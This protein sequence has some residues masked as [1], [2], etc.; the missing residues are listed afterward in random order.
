MNYTAVTLKPIDY[1]PLIS[2]YKGA[3]VSP[4]PRFTKPTADSMSGYSAVKIGNN[5][6]AAAGVFVTEILC[7]EKTLRAAYIGSYAC[8]AEIDEVDH[9]L[10]A[11]IKDMLE[12]TA[13]DILVCED[14]PL[15]ELLGFENKAYRNILAVSKEKLCPTEES[16]EIQNVFA[17]VELKVIMG[18]DYTDLCATYENGVH[19]D[20]PHDLL[21]LSLCSQSLKP[22]IVKNSRGKVIALM[23][24][25][26]DGTIHELH[27]ACPHDL[28]DI[29]K[30]YMILHGIKTLSVTTT[31]CDT[32]V[33][34]EILPYSIGNSLI[35]TLYYKGKEADSLYLSTLI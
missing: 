29:L 35:S 27:T 16:T 2:F 11:R 32:Q 20:I 18:E 8:M 25:K 4:L 12:K 34:E 33:Y 19:F 13:Y 31:P 23:L 6:I 22:V 5:I 17:F 24:L 21:R 9:A 30:A 7:G 10:A 28:P 3:D 15:A 26:P 14:C 1:F